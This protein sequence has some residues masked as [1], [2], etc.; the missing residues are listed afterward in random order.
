MEGKIVFIRIRGMTVVY[1]NQFLGDEHQVLRAP[2]SWSEIFFFIK[3]GEGKLFFFGLG[4][5]SQ[6]LVNTQTLAISLR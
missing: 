5:N 1:S 2:E 3:N 4:V 6:K